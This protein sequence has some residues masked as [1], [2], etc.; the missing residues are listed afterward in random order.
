MSADN[1]VYVAKFPTCWRVCYGAA[2]ENIDHYPVGT[3]ER[4]EELK[5]YFGG[6]PIYKTRE[7]AMNAA[8]ILA[9]AY[10]YLEYGICLLRGEYEEFDVVEN[11]TP[12]WDW[13]S[14]RNIKPTEMQLFMGDKRIANLQGNK[15]F[16]DVEEL[17]RMANLGVKTHQAEVQERVKA[18]DYDP[19]EVAFPRHDEEPENLPI[20]DNAL[21]VMPCD[22]DP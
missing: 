22:V 9:D 10:E 1:G 14:I 2:I 18:L 3:P 6:S 11:V 21:E 17:V 19:K 8:T 4:L 15:H 13:F 16:H 20:V 7:E 5:S 12:D